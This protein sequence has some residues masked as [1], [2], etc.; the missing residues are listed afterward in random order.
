MPVAVLLHQEQAASDRAHAP[1]NDRTGACGS[2][3][4]ADECWRPREMVE[5]TTEEMQGLH[6]AL[7]HA[8]RSISADLTVPDLKLPA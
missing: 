4:I 3:S 1:T 8:P 7:E 6:V 5:K 2:L